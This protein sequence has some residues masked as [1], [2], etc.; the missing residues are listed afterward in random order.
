MLAVN[1]AATRTA[2]Y[3]L[4]RE[5]EG[6]AGFEERLIGVS[7]PG[8]GPIHPTAFRER[9]LGPGD[10]HALVD[11]VSIARV[12]ALAVRDRRSETRAHRGEALADRVRPDVGA[13]QDS[14]SAPEGYQICVLSR[15]VQLMPP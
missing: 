9:N 1:E 7:P 4:A 13:E 12:H 15:L 6:S 10:R 5:I 8:V 11:L 2:C 14:F 3:A